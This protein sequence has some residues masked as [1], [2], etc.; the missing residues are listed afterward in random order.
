VALL[1]T[2]RRSGLAGLLLT[3]VVAASASAAPTVSVRVEG[4]NS[5]LL[6][7]TPITLLDG[8]EPNTGCPGTSGSAAL[9]LA[10]HGNWDRQ[11]YTQT[12]LGETHDFSADSD[13]WGIWV[14]RGGRYVVANGLCDEQLAQG[15]ELLAAY[16]QAPPP[17]YAPLVFPMW[18]TG[19]PSTVA[20]GAPFTVTVYETQCEQYCSPGEGHAV[21]RTGATVT[22]GD[23][24]ATTD[25]QGQATLVLTQPGPASVRATRAGNTP[26]AAEPTCATTGSD[27]ACGSTQPAPATTTPAGPDRTAPE[28]RIAGIPEQARYS[29]KSA[30]R[31]LKGSVKADPSGLRWVQLRLTRRSHGRCWYFSGSK[32]RFRK[33]RCGR[34]FAFRIGDKSDWSYLLPA[35]LTPGRYVLDALAVDGANNHERP[36]R[37][38]NRIVFFVR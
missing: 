32:E 25:G 13:Y 37:G 8:S 24:S 38:R 6:A 35:R 18:V 11:A 12:I 30:P 33:T 16:E 23:V 17:D 34:S 20:P 22:A 5:T 14:F 29:T 4:Q 3:L 28:G 2:F 27:G 21:P 1:I 10:T 7:R 19:V 15:E 36:A 9:E 31:E 26:T